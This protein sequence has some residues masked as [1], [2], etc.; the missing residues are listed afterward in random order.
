M[1]INA[2]SSSTSVSSASSSA[3]VNS[4]SNSDSAKKTSTD[5]SFKEEMNKVSD[6]EKTTEENTA[7]K[8]EKSEA[9]ESKTEQNTQNED[10]TD[11][12]NRQAQDFNSTLE[13]NVDYSQYAS[14]S[15]ANV[16]SMLS[17]D[18][19]Q[20]ANNVY[21]LNEI[22]QSAVST[23]KEFTA[24]NTVSM[25]QS[26]A[27]FFINLTKNNDVSV[28][29]IT[30]QAQNMVNNGA[31]AKEVQQNVKISQTLLNAI[32]TAKENN[33]PLR[34]DFDQN[35]SVIMRVSKDGVISA[36]FIP[37]DRAVEQYLKNNIDS[38]RAAFNEQD[39]PYSELS[40][41]NRGKQQ[42]KENRKNK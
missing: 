25:T 32:N 4:A 2:P 14:L 22:S 20:M 16:N 6:T 21:S 3:Q 41:S 9:V 33:Q 10:T 39:L 12:Q 28:Q 15:M 7:G 18:I 38:L 37:G 1:S 17:N 19:A 5:S 30:S 36:S 40:Y 24:A 29:N 8:S 42:Q 35:V 13:G 34:I 11:N 31:E 27:D 26:D 23:A